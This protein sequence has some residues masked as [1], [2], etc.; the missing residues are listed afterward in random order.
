MFKFYYNRHLQERERVILSSAIYR[1]WL[2]VAAIE[3]PDSDYMQEAY[4]NKNLK[5]ESNLI[6]DQ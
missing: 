5:T 2:F 6:Q 4:K 1:L 3:K